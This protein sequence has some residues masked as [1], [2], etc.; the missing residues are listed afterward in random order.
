M[1]PVRKNRLIDKKN[2]NQIRNY[3]A[4]WVNYEKHGTAISGV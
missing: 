4:N 2:L 3:Y 1:P